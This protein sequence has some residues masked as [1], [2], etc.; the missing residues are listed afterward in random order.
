MIDDSDV[1][2]F[3]EARPALRGLAYRILGSFAEAEDAVQDTVVKWQAADRSR[4]ETPAA[5]LTTVCTRRCLD[6][7]KAADRSR[8]DYVGP[9]LPEPVPTT[10]GDSTAARAASVTNAF[11]LLLDRLTPKERAAYLLREIFDHDYAEVAAILGLQEA[12]CRKL[13]SRAQAAI[14]EGKARQAAPVA[15]QERLLDA[16]QL[17]VNSGTTGPLSALLAD[18][19]APR[20]DGGGKVEASNR[21]LTGREEVMGFLTRVLGSAWPRWRHEQNGKTE[22]G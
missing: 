15:Q 12:A 21:V 5:W 8:V 7:L 13:V 6:L 14:R 10:T 2:T 9:W 20:A 4:I 3:E 18:D 1:A 17:A 16:F 19:I 22:G 11:L